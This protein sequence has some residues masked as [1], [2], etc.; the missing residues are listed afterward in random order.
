MLHRSNHGR[1]W[2]G[3]ELAD[4]DRLIAGGAS[5]AA[6]ALALGRSIGSVSARAKQQG[7]ALNRRR[8]CL[9][10]RL[11][12]RWSAGAAGGRAIGA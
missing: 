7:L 1:L 11:T 12:T 4:L 9:T 5:T 8:S 10:G 6:I 2:S 3:D